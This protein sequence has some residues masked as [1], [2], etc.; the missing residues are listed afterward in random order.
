M[1]TQKIQIAFR[2]LK[3]GV[4]AIWIFPCV[5]SNS[6][7]RIGSLFE[8]YQ[9][10]GG[11]LAYRSFQRKVDRLERDRFVCLE[12]T[13]GGAEG[14]TTMVKFNDAVKKLTEYIPIFLKKHVLSNPSQG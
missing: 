3:Q 1:S 5:K 11:N 2:Q 7:S 12:K 13:E 14:N 10:H 8:M 6:G 4:Y 9:K